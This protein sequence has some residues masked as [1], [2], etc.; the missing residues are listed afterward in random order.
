MNVATACSIATC[1]LLR[2]VSAF[3][4]QVLPGPAN[5]RIDYGSRPRVLTGLLETELD[6]LGWAGI[7]QAVDFEAALTH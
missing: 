2:T 4:L 7:A 3:P 5:S 1:C 6:A